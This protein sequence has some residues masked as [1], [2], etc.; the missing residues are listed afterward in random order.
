MTPVCASAV[1]MSLLNLILVFE[2]GILEEQCGKAFLP[3]YMTKIIK[4]HTYRAVKKKKKKK[5]Q[6]FRYNLT[7]II[8]KKNFEKN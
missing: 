5:I 2:H 3:R 7:N 4:P 6:P 8:Y 1:F